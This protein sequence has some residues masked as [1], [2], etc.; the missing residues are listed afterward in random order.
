MIYSNNK[1]QTNLEKAKFKYF[2]S[3]IRGFSLFILIIE[4]L[5]R[6]VSKVSVTPFLSDNYSILPKLTD[7]TRECGFAQAKSFFRKFWL[8]NSP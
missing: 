6:Y 1:N 3:I 5:N 7:K 4:T 8:E 2:L